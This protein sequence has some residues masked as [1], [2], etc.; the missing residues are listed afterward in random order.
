MHVALPAPLV[1]LGA[2]VHGA[3]VVPRGRRRC[4]LVTNNVDAKLAA[5][6]EKDG[7]E[8]GSAESTPLACHVVSTDHSIQYSLRPFRLLDFIRA[9]PITRPSMRESA[10]PSF[11]IREAVVSEYSAAPE[12]ATGDPK[13]AG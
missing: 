13:E 4:I 6:L 10:R 2:A 7:I 9:D 5:R 8:P 3:A 12:A 1:V 11:R